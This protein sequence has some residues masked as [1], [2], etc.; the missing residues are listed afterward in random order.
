[1]TIRDDL[2]LL[3]PRLRR[4]ARALAQ[5]S[6]GPSETADELVHAA[7]G[8]VLEAGSVDR[9]SNLTLTAYALLTQVHRDSLQ[10]RK[11]R[12]AGYARNAAGSRPHPAHDLTKQPCGGKDPTKPPSGG[13]KDLAAPTHGGG[14]GLFEGLATLNL[15]E[16]EALLLVVVEQFSYTQAMHILDISRPTLVARLARARSR[17]SEALS[18]DFTQN[19]GQTQTRMPHLRLVK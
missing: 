9:K 17:L 3:T 12:A 16:R 1:V 5:A 10:E 18:I 13:G 19:A 8:R 6:P 2:N 7:L 14:K 11:S 15:D 4:Y